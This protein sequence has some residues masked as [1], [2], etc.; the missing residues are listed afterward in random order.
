MKIV[1]VQTDEG[2]R[3]GGVE[4]EGIRLHEGTPL[5]AWEPTEV[6]LSFAEA[7]L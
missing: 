4:E 7:K 3:Y 6:V 5:V 2:I 1:R